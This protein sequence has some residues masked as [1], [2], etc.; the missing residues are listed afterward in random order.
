M[1]RVQKNEGQARSH[2]VTSHAR[3]HT[4]TLLFLPSSRQGLSDH[5]IVSQLTMLLAGSYETST[6]TLTLSVYN[7]AR[8]PGTVNRLLEEIDS[9]F[10]DKVSVPS[11][12]SCAAKSENVTGDS[13]RLQSRMRL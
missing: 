2:T 1:I 13:S 3:V 7:L 10:P 4:L 9:T 11:H 5:K 12:V 6:L 8:N